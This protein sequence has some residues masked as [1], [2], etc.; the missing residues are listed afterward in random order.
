MTS[1]NIILATTA[2]INAANVALAKLDDI[3]RG[4]KERRVDVLTAKNEWAIMRYGPTAYKRNIAAQFCMDHI[5]KNNGAQSWGGFYTWLR[6]EQPIVDRSLDVLDQFIELCP[7][8]DAVVWAKSA[9][10]NLRDRLKDGWMPPFTMQV[11]AMDA[12]AKTPKTPA[13]KVK[14]ATVKRTTKT[15]PVVETPSPKTVFKDFRSCGLALGRPMVSED[16]EA[17]VVTAPKRRRRKATE[18]ASDQ[19]IAA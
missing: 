13:A 15:V 16:T 14:K 18:A 6:D 19:A 1:L 7:I 17:V 3:E 11:I 5:Q 12:P 4:G 9:A 2:D 8:P 10:R